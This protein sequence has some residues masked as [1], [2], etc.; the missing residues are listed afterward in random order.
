MKVPSYLSAEAIH[1]RVL[2]VLNDSTLTTLNNTVPF[3]A[4][5]T[6]YVKMILVLSVSI[7]WSLKD[8]CS[9]AFPL[10]VCGSRLPV[11]P[12]KTE[13]RFYVCYMINHLNYIIII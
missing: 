1:P 12:F 7:R 5:G 3:I 11:Y 6:V 9:E 2:T 4:L 10:V 13:S 8:A